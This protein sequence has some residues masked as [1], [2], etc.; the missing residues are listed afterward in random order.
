MYKIIK[1][2]SKTNVTPFLLKKLRH[3]KYRDYDSTNIIIINNSGKLDH[4]HNINKI[5]TLKQIITN[6]KL[7]KSTNLTHTH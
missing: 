6:Q 4:S 1:T 7:N 5:E 3:L 2:V